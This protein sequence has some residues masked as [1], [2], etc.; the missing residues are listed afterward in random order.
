MPLQCCMDEFALRRASA[1]VAVITVGVA[2]L[3]ALCAPATAGS[4]Q[5]AASLSTG[6]YYHTATTLP[7]GRVL[8]AGGNRASGNSFVFLSSAE[9]YDPATDKWTSAGTLAPALAYHAAT[10]LPSGK[11]VLFGGCEPTTPAPPQVYDPATNAWSYAGTTVPLPR[12]FPTATLLIDGRVL[13][14]GGRYGPT[15][16]LLKSAELFDPSTNTWSPVPDM[17]RERIQHAATLLP[18]GKVLVTGGLDAQNAR[19]ATAELYDPAT[20]TW[21]SAG[22]LAHA[23][24]S[25]SAT[26]LQDQTVLVA[27]GTGP[28]Q[29]PF[30]TVNGHLSSAEIYAPGSNTWT[31]T[32]AADCEEESED[33]NAPP[34]PGCLATP[35]T[36]HTATLL[37]DGTVLAAGGINLDRDGSAEI[38]HPVSRTWSS[39]GTM[40]TPRELHVATLLKDGRALIVGGWNAYGGVGTLASAEIYVPIPPPPGTLSVLRTGTGTVTSNPSGIACGPDCSETYPVNAAVTL[41]ATPPAGSVFS[42]W[43]GGCASTGPCALTL[44]TAKSVTATFNLLLGA[45]SPYS[46]EW[47]QKA[48][49]AYYGRPADPAGLA[50]WSTRMDNEG[51]SLSSI[52]AEFGTSEEFNRRYVGLSYVALVTK[53][54]Q[55]ALGRD[56]EQGGLD[57]YVGE[58]QAGRRTLQSIT[59]DVLG[60]ATGADALTVANRLDV[61]NHFT[62]KV[63]AGCAYGS[64]QTGVSS[65]GSVTPDVATAFLAKSAIEARCGP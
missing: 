7:D 61:A 38:Y 17:S 35:R 32:S 36:G 64:E 51:G 23:R 27:A 45:G 46:S 48:Y 19:I 26:L 42:G 11:V 39:A 8:V 15:G 4:F 20:N 40:S 47:V 14:V 60:G 22:T 5:P 58:L 33:S 13:L 55:Q 49:V 34:A 50:Y 2:S 12:L 63:A 31:S 56:P 29:R 1:W 16:P 54:Y 30:V 44:S 18:S 25:H 24:D 10:L 41:L 52:I 57:Y 6:R 59:L 65:L 9:I 37:A 43:S 62:G 28:I 53:I 3:G 21:S